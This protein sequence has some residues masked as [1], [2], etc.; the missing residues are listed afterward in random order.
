MAKALVERL[1]YGDVAKMCRLTSKIAPSMQLAGDPGIK[2]PACGFWFPEEWKW[3]KEWS[4][5]ETCCPLCGLYMRRICVCR[6]GE[7][8]EPTIPAYVDISRSP[9]GGE[10]V[11]DKAVAD[12]VCDEIAA[13]GD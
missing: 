10:V 4:L 12:D 2:C 6:G 1:L 9:F 13:P 11:D 7:C 8:G 5:P 3:V